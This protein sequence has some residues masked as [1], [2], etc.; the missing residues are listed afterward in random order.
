MQAQTGTVKATLGGNHSCAHDSDT[1][2]VCWAFTEH[3]AAVDAANGK[4]LW[5]L[6][7]TSADRIMPRISAVRR[8]MIYAT[9]G[10]NGPVILDGRT[11]KDKVTSVA[12]APTLVIPGYGLVLSARGG[13]FAHRATG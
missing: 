8:G 12:I 6:P 2:I 11:G 3:I 7:D 10:G 9:A 1:L 5:Q 4:V 13:L